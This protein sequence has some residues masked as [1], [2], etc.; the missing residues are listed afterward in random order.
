M[1]LRPRPNPKPRPMPRPRPSPND[2]HAAIMV[3]TLRS[4]LFRLRSC[5][6]VRDGLLMDLSALRPPSVPMSRR[7]YQIKFLRLRLWWRRIPPRLAAT[8]ASDQVLHMTGT[9]G[10]WD[11]RAVT[12][13]LRTT[14]LSYFAKSLLRPRLSPLRRLVSTSRHGMVGH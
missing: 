1:T 12:L 2:G 11:V 6:P 3:E 7:R 5:R 10:T 14:S 13:W 4:S 9:A 8:L